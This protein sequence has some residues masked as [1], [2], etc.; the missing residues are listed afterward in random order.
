MSDKREAKRQ[1]LQ[2]R[3]IRATYELIH[4]HGVSGLRAR[5][6]TAK[7][8]CALGSL[9]TV[10]SDID[11]LII[12]VNSITLGEL[13]KA[14]ERAQKKADNPAEKLKAMAREYSDFARRNTN[15]WTA[16]FEHGIKPEKMIPPWHIDDQAVLIEH[17]IEPLSQIIPGLGPEDL[18]LRARSYFA[19]VHGIVSINMEKRFVALPAQRLQSELDQFVETLIAGSKALTKSK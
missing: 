2:K 3:L 8:A 15:Q 4:E 11:D 13:G 18:E 14:L 1:D 16:L 6:I 7:A 5:D 9:Y 12:H 10:F 19:A 17:I